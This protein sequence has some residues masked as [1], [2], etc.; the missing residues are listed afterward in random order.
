MKGEIEMLTKKY[1]KEIAKIIQ[2]ELSNGGWRERVIPYITLQN[3]ANSLADY[4]AKE[5]TRFDRTKFIN[6]CGFQVIIKERE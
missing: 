5:N 3:T 1:F 4:F 6:A 2:A